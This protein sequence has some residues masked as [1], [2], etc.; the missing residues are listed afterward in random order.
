MRK[1]YCVR[2]VLFDEESPDEKFL[3]VL[4]AA[5][6]V[7]LHSILDEKSRRKAVFDL[8]C[9]D[10]T[11]DSKVWSETLAEQMKKFGYNAVSAFSVKGC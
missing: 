8:E 6:F 4:K 11:V 3:N 5:G 7:T 10:Q 1:M 2:V 9:I